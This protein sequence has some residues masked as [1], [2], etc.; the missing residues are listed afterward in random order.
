MNRTRDFKDYLFYFVMFLIICGAFLFRIYS[1]SSRPMHCDEAVHA[2]KTGILLETGKYEYN[3]SQYHGPTLY[4]FSI[5]LIWLSGFHNFVEMNETALRLVP[6]LFGMGLIFLLLFFSESIG[7][8]ESICAGLLTALS[9]AMVFYSRYYIQE[10]LLVFFTFSLILCVWKYI[11]SGKIKWIIFAGI[12]LGLMYSTKETSVLALI[13]IGLSLL[14]TSFLNHRKK[15]QNIQIHLNRSHIAIF[16]IIATIISFVLLSGFF[17]N[18]R[19]PLD[20]LLCYSK[21][22][23]RS[24]VVASST[25]IDPNAIDSDHF[26]FH[27]WYYYLKMIV[28]VKYGPGPWWSEAIILILFIIGFISSMLGKNT[29][30][31]SITITR[32]ISFFTLIMVIFY[33]AIPYKTPW[34]MLTFLFGMMIVGGVGILSIAKYFQSIPIKTFIYIIFAIGLIHLGKQAYLA[35]YRFETDTRNPYVYAH[36]SKDFL[37]LVKRIEDIS[38]LSEDKNNILI[39]IITNDYWPLPWYLRDFNQVGYWNSIPDKPDA[40]IVISKPEYEKELDLKLQNTYQKEYFGI[41]PEVL[42]LV[43]I[44][45]DLWDKFIQERE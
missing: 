38:L 24:G 25:D 20:S 17:T 44:K 33:S 16:V 27:P 35:N 39:K 32:F 37:K 14:L 11:N 12:S 13:S 36:T 45:S 6:V 3:P 23:G 19:G 42:L 2:Y 26:H 4:Y 18:L 43:Y 22:I 5:P 9:P 34:L 28:F 21:Y 1:L 7:K 41:R 29:N 10:M 40:S 8:M 30:P 15:D 31:H